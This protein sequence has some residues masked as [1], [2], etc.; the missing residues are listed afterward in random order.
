M[1]VI[2]AID[3]RHGRCVRRRQGR[4]EAEAEYYDDPVRMA[5][6]WRVMNA[7]VLHLFDRDAFDPYGLP[8]PPGAAAETRAVI[9][10][11]VHALD[12]PVE[13]SGGIT[14]LED[15]EAMLEIGAYRAVLGGPEPPAADLVEEAVRRFGSSRVVVGLDAHDRTLDGAGD[16]AER[17]AELEARGARRFVYV[18]LDR[19]GTA[20]GPN[21]EA[22]RALSGALQR[23]R[24]TAGG[25]VSGYRDLLTL[26]ALE[27]RVDS[28]IVGRALYE[29]RFPCQRF[30]AWHDK[31]AVDLDRFSTAPVAG[32]P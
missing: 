9:A 13:V 14:S 32:Q 29:N 17:A 25:G 19:A 3:L 30:W 15:V 7:K 4:Y 16:L 5:K 23:A 31:E 21:V 27:P 20:T 6:L 26:T 22:L 28:V 2:P 12:I 24:V 1:L 18:D 8:C 11:I 10:E